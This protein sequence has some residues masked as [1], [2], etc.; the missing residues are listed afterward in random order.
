MTLSHVQL[1]SNVFAIRF[2][3]DGFIRV[4]YKKSVQYF[5]DEIKAKYLI[6]SENFDE[7]KINFEKMKK[8]GLIKSL[9]QGGSN[10][11]DAENMLKQAAKKASSARNFV[12]DVS[13]GRTSA[14]GVLV[15]MGHKK[16]GLE[17]DEVLDRNTERVFKKEGIIKF[18]NLKTEEQRAR[19]YLASIFRSKK[20]S[21]QYS[22]LAENFQHTGKNI[23][24]L[25]ALIITFDIV[26]A[27]DK[28][29]EIL[30]VADSLIVSEVAVAL[31]EPSI[32]EV[33]VSTLVI[34]YVGEIVAAAC[35]VISVVGVAVLASSTSDKIL[36]N[37]MNKAPVQNAR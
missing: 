25:N 36:D 34:P 26:Y 12:M 22:D 2:I 4:N 21:D 6:N 20:T 5:V 28:V 1:V 11:L 33:C 27:K 18:K 14:V 16:G 15:A 31:T 17:F 8:A 23:I 24:I 29:A 10:E 37:V 7:F 13:R 35:A 3:E 19:I 30:R 9:F 32:V